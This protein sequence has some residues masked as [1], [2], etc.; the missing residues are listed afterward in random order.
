MVPEQPLRAP[1]LQAG[2][3]VMLVSP[4]GPARAER[5]ARG[6]ELLHSWGLDVRLGPGVYARHGYLGGSDAQRIAGLH[7]AFRDP[8]VRG[9]VCTRGGYGT[10]RIVDALDLSCVADDPK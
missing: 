8:A 2:D 3:Q 10:Q 1:A 9:V 5:V 4:S 6:A 7:A